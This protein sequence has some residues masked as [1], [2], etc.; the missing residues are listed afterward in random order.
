MTTTRKRTQLRNSSSGVENGRTDKIEDLGVGLL[1]TSG[2]YSLDDIK[3][4]FLDSIDFEKRVVKQ[5]RSSA[6]EDI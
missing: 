1:H 4:V 3:A 5:I 2:Y 6:G